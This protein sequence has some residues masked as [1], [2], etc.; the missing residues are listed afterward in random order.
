MSTTTLNLVFCLLFRNSNPLP[1]KLYFL[2]TKKEA[3]SCVI[4]FNCS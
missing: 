3:F 2:A 4:C 1:P